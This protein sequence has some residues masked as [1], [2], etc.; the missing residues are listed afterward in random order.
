MTEMTSDTTTARKD[1][2]DKHSNDPKKVS[3]LPL[4]L[5]FSV[6][7]FLWGISIIVLCWLFPIIGIRGQFGDSFGAI[8]S[9]FAGLAFA[10]VIFAIILQKK[11]LE[12]QRQELKETRDEIRG[13]KEQLQAQD[14]TLKKQNFEN[15]FFQ[16]LSF[17]NE[18][19]NSL[20]LLRGSEAI[21]GRRCF[22][23]F[24]QDLKKIYTSNP[25]KTSEQMKKDINTV[26]ERF[27]SKRQSSV[28]HY[29]RHWRCCMKG[30][31]RS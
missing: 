12:L 20:E 30:S 9:L 22:H 1:D 10:G 31:R 29:F 26:Y 15:S 6:I 14:Q 16:L 8:N 28:G 4:W 7:T 13:Q 11:E 27:L 19:V 2:M 24:L 18:I 3:W 5:T 17:H 25:L 23:F 21:R